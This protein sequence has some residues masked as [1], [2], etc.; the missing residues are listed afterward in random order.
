M[1][2]THVKQFAEKKTQRFICIQ[3]VL[4]IQQ[5]NQDSRSAGQPRRFKSFWLL[6]MVSC[7][8]IKIWMVTNSVYQLPSILSKGK[9]WNFQNG[10]LCSLL[11]VNAD[12][13]GVK[14]KSAGDANLP[15]PNC[16]V[17]PALSSH[18]SVFSKL[19]IMNTPLHL[20]L[21]LCQSCHSLRNVS[22]GGHIL[23]LIKSAYHGWVTMMTS[24]E[25]PFLVLPRAPQP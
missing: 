21:P 8:P 16:C 7:I 5:V 6:F 23:G 25:G 15:L 20:L 22:F 9:V 17:L 11:M 3:Q 2:N 4:C 14:I 13:W 24:S 10:K 1:N 19:C 18:L 12:K